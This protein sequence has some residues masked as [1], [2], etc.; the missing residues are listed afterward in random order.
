LQDTITTRKSTQIDT[1]VYPVVRPSSTLAYS[2][3]WRPNRRGL[4]STPLKRSKDQLE[5]HG[6]L[7]CLLYPVC[8]E[9]PQ[10]GASR[11]YNMMFTKKHGSKARMSNAHKT[12]NQS[13]AHTQITTRAHNTTQRV[14][15]SKGALVAI[16]KN[17]MRRI[18]VL[19][20][21]NSYRMF[22]V[23][24]HA[25]RGPFYSPKAARSR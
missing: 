18:G 17:R 1:V 3:L 25:P 23:L 6:V 15:Y 10:L 16:T 19:V 12:Q 21:R 7:L 13:T 24:L 14:L 8:E 5:Y 20:L 11:P 9:S 22:G 2:T 4:Q